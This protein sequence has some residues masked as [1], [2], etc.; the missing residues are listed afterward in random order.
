MIYILL[1]AYNEKLNLIK[2]F[3]KIDDLIIKLKLKITVVLVDDCS[4]DGTK[5][6]NKI[7]TKFKLI[8]LRHKENS[9]LSV[10]METGF[11]TIKKTAKINDI[12]I[13]LDSDNTHPISLIEMM[14]EEIHNKN[15]IV[16]ASRF[17]KNSK[18]KGVTMF[19]KLMS[20]G[21]KILFKLFF[22]FKNLNDYTCNFRAY[23]FF[24]IDKIL[25][26]KNFFK[27]EN[28]NIAAKL[29]IFLIQR[30]QYLKIKEIP[31]SL[32]YDFKIG[33]SKMK[34]I[35]TIILTLKLILFNKIS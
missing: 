16:I 8:Y 19:R 25:K 32:R 7:R 26:N 35:N 2:I 17:V 18:V 15:D 33:N 31:L 30:F 14:I 3:K 9:G 10:T 4:T 20:F 13:T 23:K 24:L 29:I 27:N 6:L 11:K 12:V 34:L 22:P 1:P 21:A 28:F 5:E